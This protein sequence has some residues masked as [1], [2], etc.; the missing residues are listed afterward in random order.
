MS[1]K[2]TSAKDSPGLKQT[3]L[4]FAP[5]KKREVKAEKKKEQPVPAKKG[6]IH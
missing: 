6:K 1:T 5:V 3:T 2:A 4:G